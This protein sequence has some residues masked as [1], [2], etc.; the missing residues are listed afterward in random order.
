MDEPRFNYF[1]YNTE[2]E[3]AFVVVAAS[4]FFLAPLTGL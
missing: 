1:N 4:T 3:D 2:I